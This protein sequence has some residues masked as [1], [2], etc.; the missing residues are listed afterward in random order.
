[1]TEQAVLS[2]TSTA[3]R[4][5]G[6]VFIIVD[7]CKG[8]EFCVEFCPK[9]ILAMSEQFNDKGYHVPIVLQEGVCS[10]CK[11]CQLLCPEF[12]MYIVKVEG[13]RG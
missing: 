13:A 4:S 3:R 12:A 9:D 11:L 5:Y 6:Q 7:R 8:C 2:K 1:M 10:D